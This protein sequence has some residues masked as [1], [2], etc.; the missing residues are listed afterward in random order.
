MDAIGLLKKDH[1]YIQ[2]L[3]NKFD[4]VNRN[5]FDKKFKIYDEI[6][7][8]LELHTHVEEEFFYPVVKELGPQGKALVSEAMREHKDVNTLIGQIDRLESSD[9]NFDDRVQ[10]LIEQAEHH[11]GEEEQE[12]FQFVQE[13]C[14]REQLQDIGRAIHD[15]VRSRR[16][17]RGGKVA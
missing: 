1:S 3:F 15:V 7:A 11:I 8:E 14:S 13:N 12:I 6:R 9:A 2:G 5:N 17:L 10:S 16:N 4:R